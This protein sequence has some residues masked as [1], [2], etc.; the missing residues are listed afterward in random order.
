[1]LEEGRKVKNMLS[2]ERLI[3]EELKRDK[4]RELQGLGVDPKFT[5]Q[6]ARKKIEV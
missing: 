5:T 1:M 6:I 3:L 2:S 4:V